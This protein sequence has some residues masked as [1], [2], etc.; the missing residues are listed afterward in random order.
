MVLFV[1][2]SVPALTM[3]PPSRAELPL[4]VLLVSVSVPLK[5]L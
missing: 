3:P 2:L 1:R 5:L 4:T